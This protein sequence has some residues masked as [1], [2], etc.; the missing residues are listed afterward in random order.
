MFESSACRKRVSY[1][2]LYVSATLKHNK[3]NLKDLKAA[4]GLEIVH[5]LDSNRQFS[6][7]VTLKFDGWPRKI[8]GHPLYYIKI[9]YWSYS[10]ETL[11][12]GKNWWI[13]LVLPWNLTDDVEKRKGHLFYTTLSFVHH[14]KAIRQF[15]LELQSGNAQFGSKS[16][17]LLSCGTL[18]FH[19]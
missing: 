17:I 18:K 2:Q 7:F 9:S 3:A 14:F 8:I 15:K 6:A 1:I 10:P 12:S 5:N 13:L 11:N 16:A 19:G 4:T